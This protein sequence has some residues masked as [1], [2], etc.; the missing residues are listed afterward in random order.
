MN[1]KKF[2]LNLTKTELETLHW[3]VLSSIDYLIEEADP[4]FGTP[5]V[6]I[7]ELDKI[8]IKLRKKIAGI[9]NV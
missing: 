4:V 7:G 9:R 2:T 1:E 5:P 6:I 8:A 3:C